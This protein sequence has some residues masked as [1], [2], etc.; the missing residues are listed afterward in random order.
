MG[1]ELRHV[2]LEATVDPS[3][4]DQLSQ[5]VW[6]N[7]TGKTVFIRHVASRFRGISTGIG[8]IIEVQVS[9]QNGFLQN[10]DEQWALNHD[11]A[12]PFTNAQITTQRDRAFYE[13]ALELEPGDALRQHVNGSSGIGAGELSLDISYNI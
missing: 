8:D 11:G 3:G 7:Q 12:P 13:G 6:V 4:A 10:N 5:N 1:K 2:H 9:K